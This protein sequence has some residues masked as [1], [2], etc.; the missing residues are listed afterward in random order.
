M[1]KVRVGS[2][3]PEEHWQDRVT[4]SILFICF[5]AK[6]SCCTCT[7]KCS[8]EASADKY[9]CRKDVAYKA[10]PLTEE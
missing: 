3:S 9:A 5:A 1:R 2:Y 4:C 7:S 10:Y 8:D 6:A